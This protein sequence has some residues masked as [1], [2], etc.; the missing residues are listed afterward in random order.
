VLL[1]PPFILEETHIELI[2]DRLEEA[3]DQV[4]DQAR[5]A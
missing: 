5:A 2:V 3:L 4:F 1:A